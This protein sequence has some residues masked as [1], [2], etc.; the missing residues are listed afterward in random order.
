VEE[1]VSVEMVEAVDELDYPL[2]CHLHLYSLLH[3]VCYLFFEV[4]T[5]CKVGHLIA[6]PEDAI[7]D[8]LGEGVDLFEN[9]V[10]RKFLQPF[11]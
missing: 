9:V 7:F 10:V 1:S 3:S 8:I 2:C 4:L 6:F 11:Y 5:D